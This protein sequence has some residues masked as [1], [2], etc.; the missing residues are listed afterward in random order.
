[1]TEAPTIDTDV[2]TVE[3]LDVSPWTNLARSYTEAARFA[4]DIG[5][6]DAAR[7]IMRGLA[8]ACTPLVIH[9]PD[10]EGADA[11]GDTD[12]TPRLGTS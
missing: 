12:P 8:A 6:Q 7:S 1:M 10:T 3:P 11:P 5:E 4:Q 9:R 2:M